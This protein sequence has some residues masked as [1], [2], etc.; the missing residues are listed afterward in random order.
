[1]PRQHSCTLNGEITPL[2][3]HAAEQKNCAG[4]GVVICS[5]YAMICSWFMTMNLDVVCTYAFTCK[6]VS[7]NPSLYSTFE[8]MPTS[9]EL[10]DGS[11]T[12][13]QHL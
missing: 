10:R 5:Q 3:N 2:T 12:C 13:H 9:T 7:I 1:M 4:D 8:M 6:C 11:F